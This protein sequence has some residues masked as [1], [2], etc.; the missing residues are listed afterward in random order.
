MPGATLQL[1]ATGI[2]DTFLLTNNIK[3]SFFEYAYFKY[4]NFA[5]EIIKIPTNQRVNW[6]KKISVSVPRHGHL[7]SNLYLRLQ[8][9]KLTITSGTWAGYSDTLGYAIFD[10][11]ELEIGGII[12]ETLQPQFMDITD[13]LTQDNGRQGKNLMILKSDTYIA[14]RFNA[15]IDKTLMIPL[16][17]FFT[18]QYNLSLPLVSLTNPAIKIHFELKNFDKCIHYDGNTPPTFQEIINADIYGEYMYL[19]EQ[20]LTEFENREHHFIVDS[21]Q[22]NEIESISPNLTTHISTLKF[23][24]PVRE[25]LFIL[26]DE[27]SINN[28]DHFNYSRYNDQSPLLQ[29]ASLFLENQARFL[30]LPEIY[31]RT[32]FPY[33]QH[34]VIPN[35]YIYTMPFALN[36]ETN[37]PTGTLNFSRFDNVSLHLK[38]TNNNPETFLYVFAVYHN[39]ITISN[40]S[41][42]LEFST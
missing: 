13:E 22:Y 32:V 1:Q 35:R 11:L 24:Q 23:N 16:P 27:N 6:G 28:N 38:L 25:L 8:L 17:F 40:G 42:H 18:K 7:L 39:F 2:Q 5:T 31:L 37:Q 29:S 34:S 15:L 19:D 20:I 4:V 10:K 21:V 12:V 3:N 26:V 41:L 30:D 14:T 36:T 9:P 33:K